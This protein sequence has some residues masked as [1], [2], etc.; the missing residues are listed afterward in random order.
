MHRLG[1]LQVG[2]NAT[3]HAHDVIRV[4]TEVVIPRSCCRPH[5]VVLQQ[6]RVHEHTQLCAVTKGRHATFVFGNPKGG[7]EDL[8]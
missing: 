5:L 2:D 8:A 6:I 1:A 4:R 7:D 3:G